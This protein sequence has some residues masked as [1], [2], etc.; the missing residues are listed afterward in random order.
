ML[1][2]Q[3]CIEMCDLTEEE[4]EAIA[5]H[6]HIPDIVAAELGNYLVHTDTGNP[7]IR[8]IILDDIQHARDHGHSEEVEKL[9]LVLKHFIATHPE[10]STAA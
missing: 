3:D 5:E 9:E 8:R 7:M 4:V 6:E 10:R 2:Y 1:T